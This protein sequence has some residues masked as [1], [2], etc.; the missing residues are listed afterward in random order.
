MGK[1]SNINLDG[2]E[3]SVLKAIGVGGGEVS[4]KELRDRAPELVEAELIDTIKGLLAFGYVV[5]DKNAFHDFASL[6]ATHFHVNSGYAKSLREA[7]D[8]RPSQ[9]NRRSKRLRR[10]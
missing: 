1:T 10:E 5:A 6:D 9:D 4:G 8:P 2:L 3:V 7:M